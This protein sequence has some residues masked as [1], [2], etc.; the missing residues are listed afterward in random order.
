MKLTKLSILI[1]IIVLLS[2][3]GIVCAH[4]NTQTSNTDFNKSIFNTTE[5]MN[6]TQNTIVQTNQQNITDKNNTTDIND[7]ISTKI[8]KIPVTVIVYS[9]Y[10]AKTKEYKNPIEGVTCTLEGQK[11]HK[12]VDNGVTNEKGVCY[13]EGNPFSHYHVK[14]SNDG[15]TKNIDVFS[16][17]GIGVPT[18]GPI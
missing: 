16:H 18:V 10:D 1:L 8:G 2:G 6:I 7:N 17:V 4:D 3:I 12:A 14:I 9:Q 15:K 5:L 13:L 11:T